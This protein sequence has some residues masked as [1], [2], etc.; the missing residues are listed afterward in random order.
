MD[1]VCNGSA[2]RRFV[3]TCENRPR[4]LT[5]VD[6]TMDRMRFTNVWWE[7]QPSVTVRRRSTLEFTF[8]RRRQQTHEPRAQATD[9]CAAA[10]AADSCVAIEFDFRWPGAVA[11]GL[12]LPLAGS[13]DRGTRSARR[14]RS[15]AGHSRGA[16]GHAGRGAVAA[17]TGRAACCQWAGAGAI[18]VSCAD[19][20]ADRSRDHAGGQ[21]EGRAQ[22]NDSRRDRWG[23]CANGFARRSAR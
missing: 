4:S 16:G 17:G 12:R 22:S 11:S 18:R 14:S 21:S 15:A 2:L 13:T 20:A 23:P 3:R 1:S 10:L 8:Q 19:H 9:A 5:G 7:G 6:M